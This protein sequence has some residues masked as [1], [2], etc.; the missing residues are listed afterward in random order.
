MVEI[1]L[2]EQ[3][4]AFAD[5][6]TLFAAAQA[7]HTSQPALTRSMKKLESVLGVTLF[8]RK[9][10]HLFLNETGRYAVDYARRVLEDDREFTVRVRAYDKG[11]HTLSIG[12]C[13]PVPQTV[14]LPLL[15]NLF[16]GMTL[17]TDMMDDASFPDRLI[18]GEYQL[19]VLHY[20]PE[21]ERIYSKKC[22]HED[23]FISLRPGNPLAFYPELHLCDLDGMSILLLSRIGFWANQHR[24]KTPN[25]HYLLQVEQQAFEELSQSSDYPVFTSSYYLRLGNVS[26]DRIHIPLADSECHTDYYIACLDREKGRFQTLFQQISDTTI[27]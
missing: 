8:T 4:V 11:L 19:A 9:K 25:S 16:D 12:F 17:S 15:N 24:H 7:L 21:D 18:S 1:H 22:G 14:L 2:L 27:L 26:A 23:L 6:G 5:T 20:Q 10:N 13:A 3:L